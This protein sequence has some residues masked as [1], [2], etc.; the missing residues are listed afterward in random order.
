MKEILIKYPIKILQTELIN[1]RTNFRLA[2]KKIIEILKNMK[3]IKKLSKEQLIDLLIE[4]NYDINKLPKLEEKKV[5]SKKELEDKKQKLKELEDKKQKL[6]E[7]EERRLE[8]EED[9]KKN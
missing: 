8:E 9:K 4:Y 5:V 6:K 1:I 2:K 7:E 3:S